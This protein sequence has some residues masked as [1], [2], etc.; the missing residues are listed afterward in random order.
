M[1]SRINTQTSKANAS[2][3][4]AAPSSPTAS[5]LAS[6]AAEGTT[7]SID[8]TVIAGG[9]VRVRANEDL[10]FQGLAGAAAGGF[11]GVGA[12]VLVMVNSSN[13]EARV[14]GAARITAGSDPADTIEVSAT[15]N[16][17]VHSIAFIGTAGVVAV[18]AQVA[19]L[20]DTSKQWAHVDTGA[21]LRQSGGGITVSA[22][23]A[24][25]VWALGVAVAL[26]GIAAGASV[27]V[28][29][30]HG[31][32]IAEIGDVAVAGVGAVKGRRS[33]PRRR[34][35]HRPPPTRSRAGSVAGIG[36]AIAI[37][38]L[39]GV[40]RAKSGAHGPLGS[41]GL[42]ISAIGDH[43]KVKADTL[44]IATGASAVGL[45]IA[46]ATDARSTEAVMTST[47]SHTTSG[48][49]AIT[50]QATNK[51][52]ADAP[53]G[54]LGGMSLA[55]MIPSAT[56]SGATLATVDGSISGASKITVRAQGEN[57]ATS[58]ANILGLSIVGIS[59]AVATAKV[60]DTA[61]VEALVGSGASLGSTGEVKVEAVLVGVGNTAIATANA[62]NLGG[63]G[64]GSIMVA[65][66]TV[67]GGVRA[68]LD[69]DV[70]ASSKV[71]V[72]ATGTNDAQGRTSSSRRAS[73]TPAAVRAPWRTSRRTRTSRPSS[74]P[75]TQITSSG[76]VSVTATGDN[77]AICA[78][79]HRHRRPARD[80]R[81][82]S[83]PRGSPATSGRNSRV[84]SCRRRP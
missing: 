55:V 19:V 81:R 35:R 48:E 79:R 9:R 3:A 63:I 67:A 66:A 37:V 41:G 33:A 74:A 84:T 40:T 11:V 82:A 23:A 60:T 52:T 7:A 10:F 45:T 25:D 49:A 36:G 30:A 43:G 4:A 39:T 61:D 47:A 16:S 73:G 15:L 1:N 5:A 53:G 27:V 21:Q 65:D 2:I 46:I 12:A 32:T 42:S 78:L 83:R 14:G 13:V 72:N 26:A 56:V 70:T 64:V 54:S 71:T 24:R 68:R 58:T 62:A 75:S 77:E 18:G 76:A 29:G 51:A 6:P 38:D 20:D 44:N 59:G 50:A 22:T 69:G 34:C 8:G 57:S 80:Q 17:M 28:V 31:D